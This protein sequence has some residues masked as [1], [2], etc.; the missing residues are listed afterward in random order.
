MA[1]VAEVLNT[2][3]RV[4]GVVGSMLGEV[5]DFCVWCCRVHDGRDV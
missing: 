3:T 5:R 2:G 1:E 4:T